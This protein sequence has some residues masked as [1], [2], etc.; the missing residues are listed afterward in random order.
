MND[1]KIKH[2]IKNLIKTIAL[3][4]SLFIIFSVIS[5]VKS[6]PFLTENMILYLLKVTGITLTIALAFSLHLMSGSFDFS[7][8][9]IVYLS[10][11]IAGNI[12]LDNN[13]GPY[14]MLGIAILAGIILSMING[15]L[16]IILRM[17]AMVISLAMLMIYEAL[18]QIVFRGKGLR[19]MNDLEYA[20]FGRP[21]GVYI[22][23]LICIVLVWFSMKYT[24]FGF[25]TRL[26]AYGQKIAVESGINEKSNILIR[27]AI[28][29]FML[30]IAGVMNI[31]TVMTL[32]AV[33]NMSST[34]IMFGALIPV[35]I[36]LELAK[37]SNIPIGVL[38]GVLSMKIIDIGFTC[39]G[40]SGTISTII[41]GAFLLA[42][43]I[44]TKNKDRIFKKILPL[45][46]GK[47][48]K[49]TF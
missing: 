27:Y 49:R 25:Q 2:S 24:R 46:K 28:C 22:L 13:L 47:M 6:N 35:I 21:E 26:L 41:S 30:G 42:F 39:M 44:I 18:T 32:V 37:Y 9:A 14:G 3:P 16:Y 38:S 19:I 20:I 12:A 36:G 5:V 31:S 48:T 10:I 34:G 11:I 29:G 23:S 17:P 4:L 1:M 8:G 40:T 45:S 43:V 33:K 15:G 7:L